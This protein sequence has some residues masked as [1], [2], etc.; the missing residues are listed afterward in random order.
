MIGSVFLFAVFAVLAFQP[1]VQA[2]NKLVSEDI[3]ALRMPALTIALKVIT[4][5]GDW[6]CY[7][8]VTIILCVI[9]GTRRVGFCCGITLA[10]S[11][12]LNEGL[13][14]IIAL[15][16]PDIS[17][18]VSVNGYTFPSGHAMNG[19]VFVGLL[20]V[21]L[22][23]R[24]KGRAGKAIVHSAACVFLL[25]VGFS[26]VYLGVHYPIDVA[27]GYTAGGAVLCAA[28]LVTETLWANT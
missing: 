22:A 1:D 8:P 4:H 18:L 19:T 3:Y 5:M 14:R 10:A 6:Y 26:R 2:W 21:L 25:A 27:A 9:L 11:W 15:S 7:L 23:R 13:K 12:L 17:Q 28:L 20:A 16:R 24:I